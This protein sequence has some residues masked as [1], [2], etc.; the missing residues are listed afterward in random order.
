MPSRRDEL[1]SYQF[2]VQRVVSALVQRETDPAQSPFRRAAGATMAS[3]LIAVIVAAG[4]GI[5]GVFTKSGDRSWKT[6]GAVII[7]KGTG[8]VYVWRDNRLHPA[9]NLASA[10]LASTSG[11]PT[12]FEVSSKS[13]ADVPRGQ[14]IGIPLLPASLPAAKDMVGLPWTVCSLALPTG[15]AS[16]VLVGQRPPGRLVAGDEAFVLESAS[17]QTSGTQTY[18]LWR[19]RAYELVD[20]SADVMK[21]GIRPTIV[22]QAFLVGVTRGDVVR[23]L[24]VPGANQQFSGNKSWNVGEVLK[25]TG[26]PELRYILV[27]QDGLFWVSEFQAYLLGSKQHEVTVSGLSAFKIGDTLLPKPTG[28]ND[29]PLNTPKLTPYGGSLC[30]VVTDDLGNA[31]LFADVQVDVASRPQTASRST[32]G[33]TYADFVLVPGGKGAIVSSGQTVSLITE[34]GVRYAAT[35][36]GVLERFGYEGAKRVRLPSSMV[37]LIPEGPGLDPQ[38]ASVGVNPA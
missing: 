25:V 27:R 15:A 38:R 33:A 35:V 17:K 11:K 31:E 9:L 2:M 8:A 3:V 18:L 28:P 19:G 16:A 36:P 14:T 7:E 21:A 29:P 6:D 4:F 26:G 12:K 5:Y 1:H 30:S 22:S 23:K 13:L 10:Y 20:G 24:N 34:N 32:T 37:S